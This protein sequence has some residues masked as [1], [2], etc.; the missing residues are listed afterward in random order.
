MNT[1][2][3]RWIT[4]AVLLVTLL[5]CHEEDNSSRVKRTIIVYLAGDNSLNGYMIKNIADMQLGM[6]QADGRLVVYFDG[7]NAAPE[8]FEIAFTGKDTAEKRHIVNYPEENSAAP[9]TLQRVLED[10]KTLFPADS[11]G[12]ILGSHATGW[13][14]ANAKITALS[15]S[16]RLEEERPPTRTFG[17]DRSS[18]SAQMDVR[19]MADAIPPGFDFIFFDAC[20]MSSIEVLHELRDKTRYLVVTPAEIVATGFPYADV[21]HYF[22]GDV[23]S[24]KKACEYFYNLYDKNQKSSFASIALVD[25][26]GLNDL[27]SIARE[28]FAGKKDEVA[29]IP[30]SASPGTIFKYPRINIPN[31]VYFDLREFVKYMAT[32]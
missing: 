29:A 6:K 31:D 28:V 22:W 25:A 8:L 14:P 13:L 7:S 16:E 17:E 23:N 30:A 19:E 3:I 21:L 1:R 12:L 18:A 26:T 5:A 9:A 10:A 4:S 24:L 20:M 2:T 27:Y 15:L 11:Y 32:G